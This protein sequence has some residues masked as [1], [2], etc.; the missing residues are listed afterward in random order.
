MSEPVSPR[1]VYSGSAPNTAALLEQLGIRNADVV[2]WNDGG[3]LALR[4]AFTHPYLVRR[5]F[6]SGVGLGAPPET[7]KELGAEKDFL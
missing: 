7:V 5:D 2:G 6:V 3:Q 4:L 1:G